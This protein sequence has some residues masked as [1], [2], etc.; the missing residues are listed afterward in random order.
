MR[1]KGKGSML[2]RRLGKEGE[3]I[4]V[5][6]QKKPL[7]IFL[8]DALFRE[9]GQMLFKAHERVFCAVAVARSVLG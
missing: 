3:G 7:P 4:F 9:Q 1:D 5:K 2:V 8:E 6:E